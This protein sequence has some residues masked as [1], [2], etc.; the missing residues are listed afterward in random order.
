MILI[1]LQ[2][3]IIKIFVEKNK[4]VQKNNLEKLKKNMVERVNKSLIQMINSFN[5]LNNSLN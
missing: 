4:I 1:I 5:R 2:L 3:L